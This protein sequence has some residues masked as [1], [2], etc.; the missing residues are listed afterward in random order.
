MP[1]SASQPRPRRTRY[2]SAKKGFATTGCQTASMGLVTTEFGMNWNA[3]RLANI[4][5]QLYNKV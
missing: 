4:A 2:E 5:R 3:M 1:R